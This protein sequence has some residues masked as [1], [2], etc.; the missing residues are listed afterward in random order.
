MIK[1][2]KN[3]FS[4]HIDEQKHRRYAYLF[5]KTKRARLQVEIILFIMDD[6]NFVLSITLLNTSCSIR[7]NLEY[8]S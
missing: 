1:V 3:T 6:A 8:N 2:R 7:D 4:I 5:V